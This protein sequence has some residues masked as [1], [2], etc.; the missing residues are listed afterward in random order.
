MKY[1]LL[2]FLFFSISICSAQSGFEMNPQ[3]FA[4]QEMNAPKRTLDKLMELSKSWA[5]Y[6]NKTGYDISEVTQNSFVIEAR[7]ENAY[8]LYNVGV[9][10]N[11]DIRYRLKIVFED[12]QKYTFSFSVKEIYT[13]N[14]MVKTT[15]ADFFTADGKVK[16]DFKDAKTSLEKTA[17]K[18]LKSFDAFIAQ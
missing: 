13:E 16:D 3:G 12:N 14:I 11:Y 6:Y 7:I 4:T 8:R 5:A 9:K 1:F 17:D 10:Y 15:T 2:T 18:I